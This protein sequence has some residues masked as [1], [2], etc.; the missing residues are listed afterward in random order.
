M[1]ARTPTTSAPGLTPSHVGSG[2]GEPLD[3]ICAGTGLAPAS[4]APGL[5]SPLPTF[6]HLQWDR[7]SPL[8]AFIGKCGSAFDPFDARLVSFTE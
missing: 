1:N 7:A 6:V 4:I 2:L 3:H 5:G 8:R